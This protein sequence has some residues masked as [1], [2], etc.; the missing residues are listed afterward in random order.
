MITGDSS[1]E[2]FT[3]EKSQVLA[4]LKEKAKFVSHLFNSIEGISCNEVSFKL[5]LSMTLMLHKDF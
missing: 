1:Y 2:T 4:E 5:I 3:K